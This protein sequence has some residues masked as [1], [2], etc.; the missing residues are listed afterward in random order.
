MQWL[1]TQMSLNDITTTTTTTTTQQRC[2]RRKYTSISSHMC[3]LACVSV[4]IVS[5]SIFVASFVNSKY[6]FIRGLFPS[7]FEK[8]G[9]FSLSR[10]NKIN[11][12]PSSF[13]SLLFFFLLFTLFGYLNCCCFF[14]ITCR[15]RNRNCHNALRVIALILAFERTKKAL[16]TVHDCENG[17][18]EHW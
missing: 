6:T 14:C 16:E 17:C 15:Y 4:C 11:I 5:L 12:F 10:S 2:L 13:S 8:I 9:F 1:R 3:C 7:M 18:F